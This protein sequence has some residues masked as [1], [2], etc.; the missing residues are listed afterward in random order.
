[1]GSGEWGGFPLPT[2]H[3]PPPALLLIQLA[4]ITLDPIA[5]LSSDGEDVVAAQL[6]RHARVAGVEPR[7]SEEMLREELA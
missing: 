3:S 2:P 6:A 5:L 4:R 1:M 7:W